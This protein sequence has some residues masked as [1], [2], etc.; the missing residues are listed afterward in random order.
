MQDLDWDIKIL[1][2]Q[3]KNTHANSC[4]NKDDINHKWTVGEKV[5]KSGSSFI[6]IGKNFLQII[7]KDS[8]MQSVSAM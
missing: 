5:L 1:Q 6:K 8:G 2:T 3:D 7:A 4:Q